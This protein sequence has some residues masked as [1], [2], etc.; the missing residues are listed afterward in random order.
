MSLYG[1]TMKR[2]ND[3][4]A[5]IM[6][7]GLGSRMGKLT[8]SIPKPLV[9]VRGVP[10]IETVIDSLEQRGVKRIYIVIGYLGEQFSYLEKKY[11]N[12]C[13]IKNEE[14]LDKN[15]ISSLKAVGN[16]FGSADCFICEADLYVADKSIFMREFE[17]SCYFG[18]MVQGYSSDWLFDTEENSRI[19]RIKRGGVDSYNMVGISY[20]KKRDAELISNEIEESYKIEGHGELFWDEIVDE[21]LEHMDVRVSEVQ[22]NSVTEVDTA[23]ELEKLEKLLEET[24]KMG[25]QNGKNGKI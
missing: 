10:L 22:E 7:A 1:M 6:A 14:Y 13:L 16:V 11:R 2:S 5:V 19:I 18:K 3:E 8:Q 24:F 12:V 20:W 4:I 25:S 23:S 21:L 9:K 15:N 17:K